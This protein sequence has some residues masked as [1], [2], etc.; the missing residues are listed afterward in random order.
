M[1][2]FHVTNNLEHVEFQI[3]NDTFKALP[4][5]RLPGNILMRYSEQIQDGKL[6]EAHKVFFGR[7]L[8]KE[9]AELFNH[10]LD[11]TE[12][13]IDIMTMAEVAQWLIEQ[14]STFP[15]VPASQ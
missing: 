5:G 14:Y 12:D 13:P 8:D 10:R 3:G 6:Y 11:S 7:V 9:S 2:K 1:K 15:T 4:K